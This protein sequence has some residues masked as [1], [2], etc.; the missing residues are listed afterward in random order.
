MQAFSRPAN[1][2]LTTTKFLNSD[3]EKSLRLLCTRLISQGTELRNPLMILLA[4]ECGLRASEIVELRVQDFS[5]D[6][7]SLF[8]RSV[9]GSNARELPLLA[10][11]SRELQTWILSQY[12]ATELRQISGQEFIFPI[13]YHALHRVWSIYRPVPKRFHSLRHTFAVNFYSRTKDVKAVQIALG[14]R[15]IMN[16]MIYVDF[17]YSQTELRRLMHGKLAAAGE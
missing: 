2:A 8:I 17:W 5:A 13:G 14:H 11:R 1:Y 10:V 7:K 12:E 6:R 3:E 16:T 15:S 9:K 4:L